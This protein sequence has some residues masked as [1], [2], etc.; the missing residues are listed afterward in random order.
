MEER[1]LRILGRRNG[2]SQRQPSLSDVEY[3][4]GGALPEVNGDKRMNP[5]PRVCAA[6]TDRGHIVGGLEHDVLVARAGYA[7]LDSSIVPRF[8]ALAY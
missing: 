8:S 1:N 4:A 7:S 2:Y 3:G 5:Q 6:L